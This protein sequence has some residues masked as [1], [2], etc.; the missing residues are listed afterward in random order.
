MGKA[1]YSEELSKTPLYL[2]SLIKEFHGSWYS[3]N[4]YEERQCNQDHMMSEIKKD[5]GETGLAIKG[6]ETPS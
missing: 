1:D 3:S 5:L 6:A 2:S 4:L